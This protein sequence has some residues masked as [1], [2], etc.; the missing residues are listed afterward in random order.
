MD[1]GQVIDTFGPSWCN[2]LLL[3]NPVERVESLGDE[4]LLAL[5]KAGNLN[6]RQARQEAHQI[7]GRNLLPGLPVIQISRHSR[8]SPS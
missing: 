8:F 6:S 5:R 2:P 3:T 7:S 1:L 4:V